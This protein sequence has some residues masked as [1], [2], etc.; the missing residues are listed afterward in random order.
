MWGAV[1]VSEIS[2][3]VEVAEGAEQ[4][5]RAFS[6]KASTAQTSFLSSKSDH[7]PEMMVSA[8]DSCRHLAW[9]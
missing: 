8:L 5:D 6:P 4:G 7:L 9:H 1:P 3:V 2:V